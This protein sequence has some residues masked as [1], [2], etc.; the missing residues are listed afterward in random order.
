M[1]EVITYDEKE[2]LPKCAVCLGRRMG[3]AG[4][5]MFEAPIGLLI[6]ELPS[7]ASDMKKELS[8]LP[9]AIN[10]TKFLAK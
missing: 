7:M 5:V 9:S 10:L 8:F 2:M 1:E 6:K 4:Q 3:W